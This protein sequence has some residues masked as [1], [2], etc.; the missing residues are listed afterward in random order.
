MQ[1]QKEEV[2]HSS[3]EKW[4]VKSINNN[5]QSLILLLQPYLVWY[6]Q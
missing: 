4:K 2:T 5:I 3:S 6:D 1:L